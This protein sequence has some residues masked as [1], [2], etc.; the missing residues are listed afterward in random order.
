M[1]YRRV[2][3]CWAR[4]SEV[5]T[6][7]IG[8][9]FHGRQSPISSVLKNTISLSLLTP[10]NV[11]GLFQSPLEDKECE[12]CKVIPPKWP[13][14]LCVNAVP[15]TS[16]FRAT[17][18]YASNCR[19]RTFPSSMRLSSDFS[20]RRKSVETPEFVPAGQE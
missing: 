1:S 6:S 12:T 7:W 3:W 9:S 18:N 5:R 14:Q 13:L 8:Q 2:R 4:Y 20:N 17:V 19:Q 15:L 11:V 16:S 10:R